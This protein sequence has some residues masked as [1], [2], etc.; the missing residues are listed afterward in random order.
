MLPTK[1]PNS[2]IL[3]EKICTQMQADFRCAS[4]DKGTL[5]LT[6]WGMDDYNEIV[7]S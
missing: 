4:K 5:D 2:R 3:K 6:E 1:D 7:T